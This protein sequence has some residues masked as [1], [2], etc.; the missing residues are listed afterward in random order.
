MTRGLL[1]T[2]S[3]NTIKGNTVTNSAG[4]S[5]DVVDGAAR[6]RISGNRISDNGDGI[7]LTNAHDTYVSDNV[8]T[9]TGLPAAQTLAAS[10]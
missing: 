10:G 2:G 6:N 3:D 4:S 7:V 8:V 1:K 9:G 5:I